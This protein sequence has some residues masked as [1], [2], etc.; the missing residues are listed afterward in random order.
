MYSIEHPNVSR[1][2]RA[3]L[4]NMLSNGSPPEFPPNFPKILGTIFRSIAQKRGANRWYYK[5]IMQLLSNIR[6]HTSNDRALAL[7]F[8]FQPSTCSSSSSTCSSSSPTCSSSSS[9]SAAKWSIAFFKPLLA[10][11]FFPVTRLESELGNT[12]SSHCLMTL[13]ILFFFCRRPVSRIVK[14]SSKSLK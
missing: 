10:W 6:Y 9:E 5:L 14:Y 8:P 7:P 3:H 2:Y 1:W 4:F 12:F 11:F 13:M